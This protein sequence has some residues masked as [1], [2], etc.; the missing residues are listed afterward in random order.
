MSVFFLEIIETI[1]H[2]LDKGGWV[3]YVILVLL[4]VLWS[5]LINKFLILSFEFPKERAGVT[6]SW[7]QRKDHQS[8]YSRR[9]KKMLLADLFRNLDSNM[10]I[11]KTLIAL[12]PLLGLLGTV[13]G[14]IEVFEV[15]ASLGNSSPRAMAAGISRATIPTMAG[16]VAALSGLLAVNI[17]NKNIEKEKHKTHEEL[18]NATS[19]S[20]N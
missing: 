9:I 2:F 15:M 20:N 16:M 14:M 7:K 1:L 19:I 6:Q 5:I 10:A 18:F 8:W 3:L 17:L 12:C 11:I 4:I 13:S